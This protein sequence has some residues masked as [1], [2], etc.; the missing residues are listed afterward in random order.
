MKFLGQTLRKH[1]A[2]GTYALAL[3][4]S[5]VVYQKS[6][7]PHR[8]S[9]AQRHANVD[10]TQDLE[11]TLSNYSDRAVLR[12]FYSALAQVYPGKSSTHHVKNSSGSHTFKTSR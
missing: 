7:T 3:V 4:C 6:V 8:L 12:W 9:E 5:L 2:C 11:H 1:L 10:L